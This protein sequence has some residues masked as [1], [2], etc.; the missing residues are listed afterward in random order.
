MSKEPIFFQTTIAN[1]E[2]KQDTHTQTEPTKNEKLAPE[3]TTNTVSEVTTAAEQIEEFD[4][5]YWISYA[6]N[7][8]QSIGLIIDET[9]ID[10][11]DNP[12]SANANSKNIGADIES[13]LNRYKSKR[14]IGRR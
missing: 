8:A 4:I 12:I 1:N 10:C 5:S 2:P 14:Q 9:A 7:Y 6:Q 3:I 13:R 11:W